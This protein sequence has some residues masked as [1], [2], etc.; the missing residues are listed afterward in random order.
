MRKTALLLFLVGIIGFLTEGCGHLNYITINHVKNQKARD[1]RA[2]NKFTD[3]VILDLQGNYTGALLAYQEA[4]LYDSTSAE[5]NLAIARDYLLLGKEESG[6]KF[7]ER[8][9]KLNPDNIEALELMSK[10]LIR[11]NKINQAEE[12]LEKI[13]SLDT[14][15][16]ESLHN[17]ALIYL[18]KRQTKKA[19]QMYN[20]ILKI[21]E[22]PNP[23]LYLRLGDLY[24]E[25]GQY[26]KAEKAFFEF[27]KLQPLNG[28][29]FYG[30]GLIGEVLKDTSKAITYYKK[31]LSLSPE[32]EQV[33]KRLE[34]MFIEQKKMHLGITFFQKH[35]QKDSSQIH[36]WFALADMYRESG[37]TLKSIDTYKSMK[38]IFPEDIQIRIELGRLYLD[39]N[40]NPS[41]YSEFKE[42]KKQ[43]TENAA[44]WLWQGINLIQ[45]DSLDAAIQNLQQALELSPQNPLGNYYL[46][47]LYIQKNRS[48]E[49][50]PHL[51]NALR[52][53]PDWIPAL[54]SLA[55][56]YE[57]IKQYSIADSLYQRI[58]KIDPDNATALNNY[59]Y[60]LSVRGVKLDKALSMARKAIK[61]NPDNG[62]FLDT[63]GWILYK[64]GNYQEALEY[65]EKA[66]SIRK[67]SAEVADHLGDVYQR[68]G[69]EEKAR[70]SWEKALELEPNNTSIKKKLKQIMD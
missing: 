70:M 63:I 44:G 65:L 10:V 52:F 25:L 11:Q 1:Q 29:G 50:I 2:V 62:S 49:S 51:K 68:L 64:K 61:M 16:I 22:T 47:V 59:G 26:E 5:I 34:V 23:E 66:F 8:T 27:N 12:Y 20:R 33:T 43:D 56:S 35:I 13:S 57:S 17:L 45:M 69:M 18:Q 28:H 32:L 42:I 54:S 31:A 37:D 36:N 7:L 4:L 55:N 60:S 19:V 41:A 38:K 53:N 30:L 14:T 58:I 48:G 67:E 40:D 3:G 15:N 24:F 9:F 46:G 21:S 39:K 6:K